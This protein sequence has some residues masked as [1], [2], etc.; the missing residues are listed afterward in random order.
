MDRREAKNVQSWEAIHALFK[1]MLATVHGVKL[2]P[3]ASLISVAIERGLNRTYYA[4]QSHG[5]LVVSQ[6]GRDQVEPYLMI[7]LIQGGEL[8][9]QLYTPGKGCEVVSKA[10]HCSPSTAIDLLVNYTNFLDSVEITDDSN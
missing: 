4:S 5:R 1:E 7:S 10:D 8:S 2:A 3:I 9:F 6:T